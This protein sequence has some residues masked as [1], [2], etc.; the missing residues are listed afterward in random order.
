MFKPR[1]VDWSDWGRRDL[2]EGE[3]NCL[4]YL[5]EGWDRKERM[6]HKD[7]IR[8]ETSWVGGRVP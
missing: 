8:G 5:K 6:G 7:F 3:G 4:K 2:H 1:K